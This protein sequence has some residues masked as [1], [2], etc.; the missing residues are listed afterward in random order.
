[1]TT[2]AHLA[3]SA[4]SMT[5]RPAVSAL[6][7]PADPARKSD[8]ELL[9]AAFLQVQG[10][11]VTLAAVADDGDVLGLD[12]VHVGIAIVVDAHRSLSFTCR[13]I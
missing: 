5:F 9:D 2:S 13:F 8:G 6:A 11:G 10:V 4:G 3:H 12:Q 1:M 7:M